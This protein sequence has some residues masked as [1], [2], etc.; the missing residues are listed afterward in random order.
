M[1]SGNFIS[2]ILAIVSVALVMGVT[3]LLIYFF[4]KVIKVITAT[5]LKSII[6]VILGIVTDIRVVGLIAAML[7]I[8]THYNYKGWHFLSMLVSFEFFCIA[9]LNVVFFLIMEW[10]PGI[11]DMLSDKLK[12]IALL[13]QGFMGIMALILAFSLVIFQ[14]PGFFEIKPFEGFEGDTFTYKEAFYY[15]IQTIFDLDVFLDMSR[16]FNFSVS[17]IKVTHYGVDGFVLSYQLMLLA[18]LVRYGRK[19]WK[20]AYSAKKNK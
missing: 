19:I 16:R 17:K 8:L 1:G 9:A 10:R 7:T 13:N 2:A 18:I 11:I 5:S 12:G 14:I 6:E 4:S 15:A 3:G 20:T